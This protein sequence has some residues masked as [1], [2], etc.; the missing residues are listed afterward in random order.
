MQTGFSKNDEKE[1]KEALEV[2]K[3][4]EAPAF[5]AIS[6]EEVLAAAPLPRAP[7]VPVLSPLW[8]FPL[9]TCAIA[10]IIP[11]L[12]KSP[13]SVSTDLTTSCLVQS[14]SGK[15]A[16][17]RSAAGKQQAHAGMFL[18]E[19]SNIKTGLES[20]MRLRAGKEVELVLTEDSD[21]E[22]TQLRTKAN[23]LSKDYILTLHDGHIYCEVNR[24]NKMVALNIVTPEAHFQVWGTKFEIVRKPQMG[25]HIGVIEGDVLITP[26]AKGLSTFH[27]L[28]GFQTQIAPG[29]DISAPVVTPLIETYYKPLT[30]PERNPRAVR[31][32]Q[33][34]GDILSIEEASAPERFEFD[35]VFEDKDAL[36]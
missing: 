25:S 27:L 14:V 2:L 19:S 1:I 20:E 32:A 28:G 34:G 15:D 9:L 24:G 23:D 21:L 18:E 10:V 33:N 8:S 26:K 5:K 36:K 3:Q 6:V 29:K 17:V 7:F 4:M 35:H 11:F 22:L 16:L 30:S 13:N 12:A 31:Q